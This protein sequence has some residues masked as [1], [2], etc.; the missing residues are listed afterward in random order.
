MLHP[1]YLFPSLYF[2]FF[3]LSVVCLILSV[4][5][6]FADACSLSA[7]VIS[8]SS[9]GV[10][11]LTP[12]LQR[13]KAD[14]RS[15]SSQC[16]WLPTVCSLPFAFFTLFPFSNLPGKLGYEIDFLCVGDVRRP[17]VHSHFHTFHTPPFRFSSAR[18]H[19]F[20]ICSQWR[21]GQGGVRK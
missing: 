12:R 15:F 4:L 2:P 1:R 16:Y 17:I 21:G 11:A 3:F 14:V 13:Q 6:L 8:A 9:R 20:F 5:R 10:I 7:V 18:F 19:S